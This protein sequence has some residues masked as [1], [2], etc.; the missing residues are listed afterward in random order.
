MLSRRVEGLLGWFF[1]GGSKARAIAGLV[2]IACG[3]A[4]AW[5]LAFGCDAAME[6][7][8][9]GSGERVRD[10][11]RDER[12]ESFTPNGVTGLSVPAERAVP[13]GVS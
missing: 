6:S 4:V 7:L 3:G 5:L 11:L 2:A 1:R 8:F 12:A 13:H 10:S 9:G